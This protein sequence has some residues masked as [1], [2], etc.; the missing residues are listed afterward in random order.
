M[1][2]TQVEE[3]ALKCQDSVMVIMFKLGI[4]LPANMD[5]I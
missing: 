2:I 3:L 1:D 5:S 4:V